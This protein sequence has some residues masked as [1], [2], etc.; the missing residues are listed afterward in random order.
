MFDVN[1]PTCT[2]KFKQ[3]E[4]T[5]KRTPTTNTKKKKNS[6]NRYWKLDRVIFMCIPCFYKI[7]F[8][9][10]IETKNVVNKFCS[11]CA[12]LIANTFPNG[13]SIVSMCMALIILFLF[14][15]GWCFII[16][17]LI[18]PV[19]FLLFFCCCQVI[20]VSLIQS[21]L[22]RIFAFKLSCF[23]FSHRFKEKAFLLLL[24]FR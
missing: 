16:S 9:F 5:T 4:T 22:K 19:Q 13:F 6:K 1:S 17:L 8:W 15:F 11:W 7:F 23:S 2:I 14:L 12:L 21:A 20:V 18:P 24:H 10:L 3:R